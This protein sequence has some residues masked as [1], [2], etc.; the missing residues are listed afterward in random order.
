MEVLAGVAIVARVVD[1]EGAVAGKG[2]MTGKGVL[3]I[4]DQTV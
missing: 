3:D 2:V 1:G 4:G